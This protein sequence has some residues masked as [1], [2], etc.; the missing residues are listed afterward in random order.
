MPAAFEFDYQ[1]RT[2]EGSLRHF[3]EVIWTARGRVPYRRESIAPTGSTV[4]VVVLGDPIVETPDA[5]RG[6]PL[7]AG[8]GFLI[9]PHDRP[10]V[11]EPTGETHAVGI[12]TTAVGCQAVFGLLPSRLRG[13]VVELEAAW[14]PAGELRRRLLADVTPARMLDVVEELLV[15]RCPTEPDPAVRRCERAVA[16]LE[17]DPARPIESIAGEVGVSHGHLDRE[18]LRVV[19]MSPRVLARLLRMRRLLDAI[20]VGDDPSWSGL[21]AAFGWFDQSHLIRDFKRHTGVTPA[22]YGEVQRAL[23]APEGPGD[24]AGFVPEP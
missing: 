2:P 5:G 1:T 9:G 23:L 18:F 15:S 12:V 22:R 8:R 20:D 3:V 4:A 21:A 16:L 7:V 10:V 24:G 17:A 19:G 13:R 11:N 14:A 6:V